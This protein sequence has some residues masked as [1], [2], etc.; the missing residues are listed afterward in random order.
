M[1][2]L[3]AILFFLVLTPLRAAE[4]GDGLREVPGALV[5]AGGGE[6]P[7]EV[8]QRF[9]Q[10]AGGKVARIV[11]IPSTSAAARD[12][13]AVGVLDY[14]RKLKLETVVL[15]HAERREQADDAAFVQPL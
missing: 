7:D 11:I 5:I 9:L 12:A 1:R 15:L 13:E 10:L 4:P 8:P 14:W 3:A 2:K 6:L